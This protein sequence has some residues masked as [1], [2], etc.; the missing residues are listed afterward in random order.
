MYCLNGRGSLSRLTTVS[1]DNG[2]Y[3]G[4]LDIARTSVLLTSTSKDASKVTL[5]GDVTIS[6][7]NTASC[8]YLTFAGGLT[9]QDSIRCAVEHCTVTGPSR[10]AV[11]L[12][13][14][15]SA[16]MNAV[17]ATRTGT[18]GDVFIIANTAN[19]GINSCS[20]TGYL[21]S[22]GAAFAIGNCNYVTFTG[23]NTA[24]T[25]AY[26]LYMSNSFI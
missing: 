13:R 15:V 17:S 14:D 5:S 22:G 3:T 23:T 18:V 19:V 4:T 25:S 1:F 21:P 2:T 7:A 11:A 26:A 20:A 9:I 8:S 12:A 10:T 6:Y 24:R 16:Y